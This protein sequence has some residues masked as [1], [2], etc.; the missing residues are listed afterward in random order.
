MGFGHVVN[1]EEI[2]NKDDDESIR[3]SDN[4]IVFSYVSPSSPQT[5]NI[6]AIKIRGCFNTEEQAKQHAAKVQKNDPNFDVWV[7]QMWKWCP[8]PPSE[9]DCESHYDQPN[10]KLNDLMSH[11]N[12]E[13]AGRNQE[14][15][16]RMEALTNTETAPYA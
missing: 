16:D 7:M 1:R 14:F 12:N 10:S 9:S 2:T 15:I 5:S 13:K 8:F 11:I 6:N 4:Y 3:T